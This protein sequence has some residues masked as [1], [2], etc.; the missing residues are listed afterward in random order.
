MNLFTYGSLMFPDVWL[1]VA[2]QAFPTRSA[3]L[4][5]FAAWK[6][7]GESYPGLAPAPAHTTTG[8]VHLG[9]TAESARR[10]DEFE[11]PF[12]ERAEVIVVLDDG[13]SMPAFAYIV[14]A[15]HRTH[16]E[17]VLWDAESFRRDHLASF[18][19]PKPID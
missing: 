2:G 1:R 16:L 13:S 17:E 8:V 10:L 3:R 5:G 19:G 11:G 15:P 6:V 14:G 18:M 7:R 12:Y 4:A 9:V